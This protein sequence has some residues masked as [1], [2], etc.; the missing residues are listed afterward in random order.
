MLRKKGFKSAEQLASAISA[1]QLTS[2]D[3]T[4][5][6]YI[7]GLGFSRMTAQA[8]LGRLSTE[9]KDIDMERPWPCGPTS[10]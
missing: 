6:E 4:K 3:A 7:F 9:A 1:P 10:S 5:F 8:R 2:E